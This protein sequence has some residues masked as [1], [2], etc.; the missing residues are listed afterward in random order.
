MDLLLFFLVQSLPAISS[1]P[2]LRKAKRPHQPQ[3]T[4]L[5]TAMQT[6]MFRN[7]PTR[8]LDKRRIRIR[9]IRRWSSTSPPSRVWS[10]Q[11]LGGLL[12]EQPI[13]CDLPPCIYLSFCSTVTTASCCLPCSWMP[14]IT[15]NFS[16]A[17]H[18][19]GE[20][21]GVDYTFTSSHFPDGGRIEQTSVHC[22]Q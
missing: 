1:N 8:M 7:P 21:T 5:A 19:C 9:R 12:L 2:L 15:S 10:S 6:R 13:A 22:I 4:M 17:C 3:A 20:E 11:S 14:I 18:F 16:I